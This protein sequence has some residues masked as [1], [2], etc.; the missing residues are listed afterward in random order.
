MSQS[1]FFATRLDLL[2]LLD[3]LE[4]D[5]RI[6]YV[7]FDVYDH[8]GAPVHQRGIDI[9][10]LGT[11]DHES[12]E[13]CTQF[14]VCHQDDDLLARRIDLYNGGVRYA[15]DQLINPN[16]IVF[17]PGGLWRENILLAGSF[18]SAPESDFSQR[19]MRRAR[20]ALRKRYR[21][22]NACYVGPE[23]EQLFLAGMR[24]T[25]AEQAPRDFDLT[26]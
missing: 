21:R 7:R 2:P 23:A 26:I 24:L 11:A 18:G 19:M 4:R 12:A 5:Q 8:P 16:T 25:F 15:Y 9:P 14:L 10:S 20:S 6:K 13:A 1:H 22:I 3:F 17:A